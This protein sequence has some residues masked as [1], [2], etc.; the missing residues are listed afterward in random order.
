MR[1]DDPRLVRIEQV[2]L[3]FFIA[4]HI[5]GVAVFLWLTLEARRLDDGPI[6]LVIG[7][8][9]AVY[10]VFAFVSGRKLLKMYR[11]R[12]LLAQARREPQG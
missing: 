6:W 1:S 12:L 2:R 8:F 7:G 4:R 5:I 11:R 9:G 10:A 3:I